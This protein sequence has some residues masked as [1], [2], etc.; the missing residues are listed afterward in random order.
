MFLFHRG[1]HVEVITV[2]YDPA[3]TTYL[4]LLNQFWNNHEYG[5]TTRV[6]R[7]YASVIF[8]HNDEQKDIAHKSLEAERAKRTG[9]Q[10][11]TEIVKADI[12]Y[13]AE[14]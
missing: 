13:A 8:Y 12:I 6:K 10:L 14:E 11:I 5:L 4:N 3:K 9:E 1:D 7:Q 2:D